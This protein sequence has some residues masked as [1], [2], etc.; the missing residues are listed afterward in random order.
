MTV[1]APTPSKRGFDTMEDDNETAQDD[2]VE[3]TF[4]GVCALVKSQMKEAP[5][6]F[7]DS[8]DGYDDFIRLLAE[9]LYEYS[10]MSG[11]GYVGP[12]DDD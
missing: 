6:V 9:K 8:S 5:G 4:E 1:P 11:S 10:N 2:L 7:P 3:E 12:E